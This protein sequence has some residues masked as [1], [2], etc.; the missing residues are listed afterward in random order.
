M[1]A[2]DTLAALKRRLRNTR[3]VEHRVRARRSQA[4]NAAMI[5]APAANAAEDQRCAPAALRAPR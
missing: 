5:A 2:T 1:N 4:T 3:D